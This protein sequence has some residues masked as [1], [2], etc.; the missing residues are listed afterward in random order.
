MRRLKRSTALLQSSR[1]C[2]RG[3]RSSTTRRDFARIKSRGGS[4]VAAVSAARGRMQ[5]VRLPLQFQFR[6]VCFRLV[7]AENVRLACGDLAW[8][9]VVCRDICVM[10]TAR[11]LALLSCDSTEAQEYEH[12][13]YSCCHDRFGREFQ[14]DYVFCSDALR[15]NSFHPP[16]ELNESM[17]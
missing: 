7:K 3:D 5:A 15:R 10:P 9:S 11:R 4:V 8:I 17:L 16:P 2:L 1:D 14:C 13:G 12:Y 6:R